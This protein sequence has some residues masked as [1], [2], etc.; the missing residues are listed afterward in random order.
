MHRTHR[1][2]CEAISRYLR[3]VLKCGEMERMIGELKS[4]YNMDHFPCGQFSAN[5]LYFAIGIFAF[6]LV[7]L[8]KQHYFGKDRRTKMH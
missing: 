8:L 2:R 1:K 5:S 3:H 7:Q 4:H 6:N